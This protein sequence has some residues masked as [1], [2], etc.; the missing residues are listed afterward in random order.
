MASSK[1]IGDQ[2]FDAVYD[3]V[4]SQDFS[5]LQSNIE[6]SISVIAT[7][8]GNGLASVSE[9]ARRS[10]ERYEQAQR[11]RQIEEQMD[12]IYAKPSAQRAS[13]IALVGW[14]LSIIVGM[15]AL[16]LG[17]ALGNLSFAALLCSLGIIAG[18]IL[19]G[20]GVGRLN[21]ANRFERYREIIGLREYCYVSEIAASTADSPKNVLKNIKLMLARGMFK[22]A[23]LGDDETFLAMTSEA[24][25]Q[26]RAARDEAL[27]GQSQK[28]RLPEA[29]KEAL[30]D[31][32]QKILKTCESYA[33]QIHAT[34]E[35]IPNDEVSQ[36]VERIER[37]VRTIISRAAESPE[38][39]EDLDHFANYYLPTTVKLLESYEEL[40][41]QPIQG[42]N[43]LQ[44]KKE[45]EG[46]LASLETAFEKLLDSIFS[47]M[48]IDVSSDVSVLHTILAQEGLVETPFEKEL[49]KAGK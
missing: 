44:S 34:C 23:A 32:D 12:L 6:K 16:T 24:Y 42:E 9:N 38:A 46:A 10:Q 45:I 43:I 5:N 40:E 19:L 41:R 36:T 26:Y 13:G 14:G 2:V 49:K 4:N 17:L 22:Q 39:I 8:I 29:S 21:L 1:N 11:K 33:D 47:D 27:Q 35:A 20:R 25:R 31:E 7:G 28:S 30:S 48:A 3:A 18:A 15:A 37:I